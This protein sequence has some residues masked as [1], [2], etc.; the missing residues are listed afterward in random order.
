MRKQMVFRFASTVVLISLLISGLIASG[1]AESTMSAETIISSD[2]AD[3]ITDHDRLWYTDPEQA[4]VYV[5]SNAAELA[6]FNQILRGADGA[7][8][9]SFKDKTVK[10]GADIVWNRGT[11]SETGFTSSAELVYQWIPAGDTSDIAWKGF[12][13]TLDGQGYSIYGLYMESADNY[14]GFFPSVRDA[15]VKNISFVNT[16]FSMNNTSDV[17]WYGGTVA[18]QAYGTHCRFENVYVNVYQNNTTSGYVQ[19]V[20][21]ILGSNGIASSNTEVAFTNC[22]VDGRIS[23]YAAVGGL[24]GT[25]TVKKAVMTDCVCYALIE[26]N[27]E[28]GGMIGRCSG[29]AALTRCHYFGDLGSVNLAYKGALVYLDRKNISTNLTAAD[30]IADVSFTDCYYKDKLTGYTY[31]RAA[32]VMNT[33]PWFHLTVSYTGEEPVRYTCTGGDII[34]TENNTL[35]GF[36]KGIRWGSAQEESYAAIVGVQEGA[37]KTESG[38]FDVRIIST[39]QTTEG[40]ENIGFEYSLFCEK[41][42]VTYP[43]YQCTAV[44]S[45]ILENYGQETIHASDYDACS[46]LF[47]LTLQG[48][49]IGATVTFAIRPYTERNGV[50]YYGAYQLI[51]YVDGEFVTALSVG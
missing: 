40:V 10:L 34:T 19:Y 30:G 15:V 28:T 2:Y 50:K 37:S 31:Y 39:L 25:N 26:S 32:S 16:Y 18:A 6:Y 47:A 45:S 5:I 48:A 9:D 46:Y 35:R 12:R 21:G 20:G 44:Y 4:D 3:L 41:G 11:I 22:T 14:L 38:K 17:Q 36:F 42:Y 27:K 13:G 33:R 23:G 29:S 43:S 8:Q 1:A 24:L 49:P 7:Q 51:S